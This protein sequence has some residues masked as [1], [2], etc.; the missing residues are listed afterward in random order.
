MEAFSLYVIYG[1]T[2]S[3]KMKNTDMDKNETDEVRMD[4][5][6]YFDVLKKIW[7]TVLEHNQ[8]SRFHQSYLHDLYAF[9]LDFYEN[10]RLSSPK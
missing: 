3:D 9:L 7:W 2:S 4:H 8:I 5:F 6:S 1:G 10:I